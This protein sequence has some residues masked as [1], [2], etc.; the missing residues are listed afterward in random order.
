M[1]GKKDWWAH[2]CL[3]GRA[4]GKLR[5]CRPTSVQVAATARLT[6]AAEADF[7]FNLPW[8][9]RQAF[10]ALLAL[11]DEARL[12]VDGAFQIFTGAKVYINQQAMLQLGSGYIN[13][14]LRLTCFERITIGHDVAIAEQVTIR[15]SDSHLIAQRPDYRMTAPITIGNHVWIGMRATILKGVTIGDGAIVAAG[16]VVIRDVPPACLVAGV[17]AR[18]I[19]RDVVWH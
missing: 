6:V 15:D 11:S 19:K 16:A 10:P 7:Q 4:S 9:R 8:I 18:V 3:R 1:N 13:E 5:L 2:F 12:Q 17:P 14:G